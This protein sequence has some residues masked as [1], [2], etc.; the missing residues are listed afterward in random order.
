MTFAVADRRRFTADTTIAASRR[1]ATM[2]TYWAHASQYRDVC[3]GCDQP[4]GIFSR[5]SAT[6]AAALPSLENFARELMQLF[7]IGLVRLNADGTPVTPQVE[8]YNNDDIGGL[9]RVFTGW[10]WAATGITEQEFRGTTVTDPL[11]RIKPMKVYPQHHEGGTKVFL[12]TTIPAG[13]T[14]E[15]A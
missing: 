8:T 11:Q 15:Q 13:T 14:G 10:S 7:T 2:P 6:K 9:A 1:V 5:I 3:S 4:Y 12:G